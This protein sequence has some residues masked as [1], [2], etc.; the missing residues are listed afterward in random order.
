MEDLTADAL[1]GNHP[2]AVLTAAADAL[3]MEWDSNGRDGADR[4]RYAA[5]FLA[6][7]AAGGDQAAEVGLTPGQDPAREEVREA[8]AAATR[9][10]SRSP[11]SARAPL[12]VLADAATLHAGFTSPTLVAAARS[13]GWDDADEDAP[14]P[15]EFLADHA[16]KGRRTTARSAAP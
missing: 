7:L 8:L 9:D 2:P 5:M 4:H 16:G 13:F 11:L 12:G 10:H 14:G 3:G 6:G 15:E 1:T